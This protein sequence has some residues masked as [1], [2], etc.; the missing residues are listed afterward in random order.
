MA[1]Q[2]IQNN[3]EDLEQPRPKPSVG[4]DANEVLNVLESFAKGEDGARS[5]SVSEPK[6]NRKKIQRSN[7]HNQ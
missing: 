1:D 3:Q 6:V 5:R 7:S 2:V 4:M